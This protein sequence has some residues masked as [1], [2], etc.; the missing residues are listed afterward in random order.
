[1]SN[2]ILHLCLALGAVATAS[3]EMHLAEVRNLHTSSTSIRERAPTSIATCLNTQTNFSSGSLTGWVASDPDDL[4]FDDEEG[5]DDILE[6]EDGASISSVVP[7][8]GGPYFQFAYNILGED[9]DAEQL[10]SDVEWLDALSN[11]ISVVSIARRTYPKQWSRDVHIL[12]APAD[13]VSARWVI[14]HVGSGKTRID[15]LCLSASAVAANAPL[16]CGVANPNFELGLGGWFWKTGGG[17]TEVK[18]KNQRAYVKRAWILT[19]AIVDGSKEH[20]LTF[21]LR[22]ER[23]VV[24]FAKWDADNAK[25]DV[26]MNR[27]TDD[28]W[29][30]ISVAIPPKPGETTLELVFQTD[31]NKAFQLDDVCLIEMPTSEAS[32]M[33][34]NGSFDEGWMGGR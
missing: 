28:E 10:F 29:V 27:D 12:E 5:R 24:V 26:L 34:A 22:A 30:N 23:E 20:Q 1:M 6:I 11:T 9:D 14:G 3:E 15:E 31:E 19:R 21:R 13:A 33:A 8:V 7:L 17:G 16:T 4:D 18:W 32:C 2:L 25:S